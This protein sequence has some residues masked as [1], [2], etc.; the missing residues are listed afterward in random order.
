MKK[1]TANINEVAEK[2]N[3]LDGRGD[4]QDNYVGFDISVEDAVWSLKAAMFPKFFGTERF[5]NWPRPMTRS[6]SASD[7]SW[8]TRKSYVKRQQVL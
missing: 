8:M 5:G 2:L 6:R 4:E 3:T 7:T 1:L